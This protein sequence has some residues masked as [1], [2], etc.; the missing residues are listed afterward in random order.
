M[1]FPSLLFTT[2]QL[3]CAEYFKRG[4]FA[5]HL[6]KT[7]A[8]Y[9]SRCQVMM[10]CVDRFF[11]AGTRRTTPEGGLFV[12][13][14]L[15]EGY[16]TTALLKKAGKYKVSFAAGE[17][18]FVEGGGMGKNCMRLTYG[19]IPEEKIRIGMERLARLLAEKC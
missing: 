7:R 16:D 2:L 19:A 14:T 3:I 11:P 1:L 6:E 5:E 17:G 9:R 18:F 13:V 12:W 10:E 15:P 4:W 8:L